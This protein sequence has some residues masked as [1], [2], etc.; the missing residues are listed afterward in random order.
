MLKV[1]LI[2]SSMGPPHPQAEAPDQRRAGAGLGKKKRQ[3]SPQEEEACLH[4]M[5]GQFQGPLTPPL[6]GGSPPKESLLGRHV[7]GAAG[8]GYSRPQKRGKPAPQHAVHILQACS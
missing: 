7:G 1:P 2:V 8:L 3:P 5:K 4:G 6:K